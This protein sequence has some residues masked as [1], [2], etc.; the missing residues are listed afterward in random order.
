MSSGCEVRGVN[1]TKP[2]ILCLKFFV[3]NLFPPKSD[4]SLEECGS[5]LFQ[6]YASFEEEHERARTKNTD[7]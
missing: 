4:Y 5:G 1:K 6:T 3:L 7:S 2:E